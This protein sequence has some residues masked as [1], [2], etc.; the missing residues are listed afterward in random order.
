M[1]YT[2]NSIE[3]LNRQIR[4]VTKTKA[5]FDKASN[6]GDLIDRV[7]KDFESNHWQS[8]PFAK[9][10]EWPRRKSIIYQTFPPS[11]ALTLKNHY[12]DLDA[13]YCRFVGYFFRNKAPGN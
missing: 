12:Y 5:T 1:L 6:M 10:S 9:F 11:W 7:I 13:N 3:N 8:Y 2:T 4:K